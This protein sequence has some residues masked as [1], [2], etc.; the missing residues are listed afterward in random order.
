MSIKW[1]LIFSPF[2]LTSAYGQ[3]TTV[4][5]EALH[6]GGIQVPK[7][8]LCDSVNLNNEK[9]KASSLLK[10]SLSEPTAFDVLQ[11]GTDT[12]FHVGK[13]N[14]GSELS[15]FKFYLA[16]T[17]FL[18]L[19]I[20]IKT[21]NAVEVY[22]DGEKNTDK[23]STEISWEKAKSTSINLKAEP[24]QYEFVVKMLANAAD[25]CEAMLKVSVQTEKRDSLAVFSFSSSNRRRYWTSDFLM[26]KKIQ[27]VSLSPNGRFA[28]TNYSYVYKDGSVG[29]CCEMSDL[30]TGKLLWKEEPNTRQVAWMPKSNNLYYL[31]KGFS[32]RELRTLDPLTLEE[33]VLLRDL[34]DGTFTWSPQE[35]Y[36][37]YS[38]SETLPIEKGDLHRIINPE[39]RQREFRSRTSLFLYDLKTGL[40]SRLTFG[41]DD[42]KLMAS[43]S[44]DK[45]I[46]FSTRRAFLPEHPFSDGSL[47]LLTL[48]NSKVDTI[49]F[50]DKYATWAT[51]SPDGKKLLVGGGPN[52]FGEIGMK[53]APGQIA[54]VYDNQL[55]LMDLTTR[56]VVPLTKDFDPAVQ[57]AQWN[58][59]DGKIYLSAEDKDYVRLFTL[60]PLTGKIAKLPL[61][62]DVIGGFDLAATAGKLVYYGSTV[63]GTGKVYAMDLKTQ[64]EK[65]LAAPGSERLAMI[66]PVK[67]EDWNFKSS[68]G[69]I[70]YGRFYLPPGFDSTKKY[71]TLVYYYGGTSPTNRS[72]ESNYPLNLYAAMGYVVYNLQPSGTT[73]FGQEFSARHVNAWGEKTADEIIQGTKLFCQEHPFADSTKLGCFGASYGGFMT[74]YLQTKTDMFK[75][76]VSH[77]GIS[78]LA[79]Y[80]G[81]GYWGYTYSSAA[82]SGSYPWNNPELYWDHSPLFHADKI[83]TPLLL[84]QGSV[85]TNVPIGESIQMFTALKIL[86]KDVEYV[87]VDSEN[88]SI[89]NFAR[90]MEW[91]RTIL[92]Y[93]ARYLKSDDRWWKELYK[94]TAVDK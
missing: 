26:G 23:N 56:K 25:S 37:I 67:V 22:V 41:T 73:G 44:D 88:H 3:K 51:F 84:L 89:R 40:K 75:A 62:P 36:L 48:E 43:S 38:V 19:K 18:P 68:D 61:L 85:D 77:A 81:E 72:F 4:L 34:P 92:A 94:P 91:Q 15:L 63:S 6:Y 46:L 1:L 49:W 53:I 59:Y 58:K 70:I 57:S 35:A 10:T 78:S 66:E 5:K 71:P 39:D 33:K 14:R 9:F 76:A 52:A 90:K 13:P 11:V 16:P 30:N 20:D 64:K 7:P 80:W 42:V 24:R 93:F 87:R 50:H 65:I 45:Q 2:I 55:F 79:S 12:I 17:D 27:S 82:S 54:N 86:G 31:S 47:F 32:G 29:S 83:K 8:I 28:L 74:M 60:D 21:P 69:T